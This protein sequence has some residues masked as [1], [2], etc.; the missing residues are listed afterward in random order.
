MSKGIAT[1][2]NGIEK[3][4]EGMVNRVNLLPGYLSRVVYKQY[5]NA[6]RERW[7]TENTTAYVDGGQWAPLDPA[8]RAYKEKKFKD[9]PGG[10]RKILIRTKR[11]MDSVVGPA[12]EQGVLVD[13][14][15]IRILTMVPYANFVDE[16]RTFSNF[17]A[18]F[19]RDVY[20]GIGQYLLKSL[21]KQL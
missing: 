12:Q 16:V 4:L 6:Q 20:K 15:S 2:A 9:Y 3:Q 1:I 11:L 17:S 7:Q 5:Q 13:E 21:V 8:Y 14:R 10:G 19:Y 18:L